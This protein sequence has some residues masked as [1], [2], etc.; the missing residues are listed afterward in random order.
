MAVTNMNKLLVAIDGSDR[1]IRTV[2]YL[3]EMPAFFNKEINLFNVFASIPESYYD[4]GREPSSIKITSGLYAWEKEQRGQIEKHM[5]KCRKILMSSDFNPKHIKIVVHK[6]RK[7]VARDIIAESKKGYGAVVLRRRGMSNLQGLIMGSI[8][9]KL[10]NGISSTSLIFAGRKPCTHRVLIAVDGSDNATRAVDFAGAW[11]SGFDYKVGLV[12]VLRQEIKN[13]KQDVSD[14]S[15]EREFVDAVEMQ[16]SQNL[17]QARDR[18]ISAGIKPSAITT[19]IVRGAQSRAAAIVDV[20]ERDDFDTIVVGRRG[21]SRVEQ[22]FAGRVS[23]KV[24]HVG[25]KH[26]VWVIN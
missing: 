19:E 17:E 23:N 20:A 10:L 1:S 21:L 14:L 9:L 4:L 24:L 6:R 25:R 5:Q 8:A 18:L 22:F 13:G 26:H 3:A 7:G 16:C 15:E 11:L 12:S 2:K